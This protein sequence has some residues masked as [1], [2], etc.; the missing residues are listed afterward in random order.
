MI[1]YLCLEEGRYLAHRVPFGCA[2]ETLLLNFV[3][4]DMESVTID[5]ANIVMYFWRAL[6]LSSPDKVASQPRVVM[7]PCPARHCQDPSVLAAARTPRFQ[8]L[9]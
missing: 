2:V 8:G 9:R 4:L 3:L 6:R 7:D 1:L 5:A